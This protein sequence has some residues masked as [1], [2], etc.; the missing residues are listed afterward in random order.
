MLFLVLWGG[1]TGNPARATASI[2]LAI[3]A[4]ASVPIQSLKAAELASIFTRTTRNWKD[5]A[6]IRPLNLPPGSAERM[7]FDR[8]ILRMEPEQ[9]AQYWVDRMVRG[10]EAAPKA[11]AKPEILV[12][13]VETT[14]GAIGYVPHDKVGGSTRV[15]ARI[16]DGKVVWP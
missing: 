4:N 12:R 10:E 6:L 3:I 2:H 13:L 1:A 8:V 15:L 7:E 5:G 11:I 9:S 14:S 16:Q